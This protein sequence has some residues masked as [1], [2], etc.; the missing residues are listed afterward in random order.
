MEGIIFT[1]KEYNIYNSSLK[2]VG[3]YVCLTSQGQGNPKV[4]LF[5]WAIEN[6][7]IWTVL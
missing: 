4:D 3:M 1:I 2:K 7:R 6:Q 5:P